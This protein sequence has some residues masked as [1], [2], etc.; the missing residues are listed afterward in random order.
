MLQKYAMK[1]HDTTNLRIKR[2][3]TKNISNK[4]NNSKHA[5]VLNVIFNYL[6][7]NIHI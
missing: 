7:N 2:L 4:H 1:H 3:K 6:C 5:K